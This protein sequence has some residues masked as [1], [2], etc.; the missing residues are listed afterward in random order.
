MEINSPVPIDPKWIHAAGG[1]EALAQFR[2]PIRRPRVL[3]TT[4]KLG[5]FSQ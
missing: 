3:I 4:I 1:P 2:I 5:F